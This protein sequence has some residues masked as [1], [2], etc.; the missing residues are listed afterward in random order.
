[1][2]KFNHQ[3]LGGFDVRRTEF[4]GP[5]GERKK[6]TTTARVMVLVDPAYLANDLGPKAMR[7]KSK[8]VRMAFG[9]IEIVV[10]SEIKS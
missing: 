5:P 3:S 1:M 9:A 6:V 4:E 2:S 8:R 7:N 10:L